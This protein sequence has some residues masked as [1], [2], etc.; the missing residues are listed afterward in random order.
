[1][2]SLP[3]SGSAGLERLLF[4][5]LHVLPRSSKHLGDFCVLLI[6]I[7]ELQLRAHDLGVL[8][9]GR[10]GTL[11]HVR[12][13][14]FAAIRDL[15]RSV[16]VL[17]LLFVPGSVQFRLSLPRA[18]VMIGKLSPLLGDAGD[19]RCN[20]G[21]VAELSLDLV[22]DIHGVHNVG[23]L[24]ALGRLGSLLHGSAALFLVSL[25]ALGGAREDPWR[26]DMRVFPCVPRPRVRWHRGEDRHSRETR[27]GGVNGIVQ[28][29]HGDSRFPARLLQRLQVRQ[30]L[31]SSEGHRTRGQKLE[32][33]W[34]GVQARPHGT[35]R[36]RG[37]P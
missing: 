26:Q 5:F 13:F 10:H 2:I 16:V 28:R 21:L 27:Q 9:K 33:L 18:A 31:A 4:F 37:Q 25:L 24:T 1:M 19:H 15:E 36:R 30:G 7:L 11:G 8:Q 6:W 34:G 29:D 17:Q 12:C 35:S 22:S 20:G 32:E 14:L 3:F 23:G